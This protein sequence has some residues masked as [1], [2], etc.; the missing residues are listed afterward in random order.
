[1]EMDASFFSKADGIL[2][3]CFRCSKKMLE[4][5]R[6]AK[7]TGHDGTIDKKN[8]FQEYGEHLLKKTKSLRVSMDA[9]KNKGNYWNHQDG[10]AYFK[11][12]NKLN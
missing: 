6:R 11:V 8:R 12:Y 1:M 10:K 2:E 7:I 3:H 5:T 9:M 4:G